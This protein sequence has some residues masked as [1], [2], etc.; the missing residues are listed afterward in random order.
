MPNV[1]V[2]IHPRHRI[3][4]DDPID[5][6]CSMAEQACAPINS[7]ELR[8]TVAIYDKGVTIVFSSPNEDY[9][10]ML[11]TGI[12]CTARFKNRRASGTGI[13]RILPT[14]EVEYV[15]DSPITNRPSIPENIVPI[16]LE[17]IE[18]YVEEWR[19]ERG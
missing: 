4:R 8:A 10:E 18:K 14:W 1:W 16:I 7:N 15:T 3:D 12:N 2:V 6:A 11:R 5:L 19:K 13:F 17:K 9:E